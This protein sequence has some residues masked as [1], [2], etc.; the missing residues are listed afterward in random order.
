VLFYT[1]ARSVFSP[2]PRSSESFSLQNAN[3][4]PQ[5]ETPEEADAAVAALQGT[6]LG[7][8]NINVEKV[9]FIS[10]WGY[11]ASGGFVRLSVL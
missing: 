9:R 1:A 3:A 11:A 4:H 5:M 6:D 8:K 10:S 7:G 2:R